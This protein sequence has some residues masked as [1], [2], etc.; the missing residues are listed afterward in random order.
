MTMIGRLMPVRGWV[1]PP[2]DAEKLADMT[3]QRDQLRAA[4][5]GLVGVAGLAELEQMEVVM[6]L[7]PAPAADKAATI[8]AI[9]ALI[10]TCGDTAKSVE[11]VSASVGEHHE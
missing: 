6:R 5:V 8:D 4:L 9:H 1:P 2:S 7:M 10:A 11:N 3:A